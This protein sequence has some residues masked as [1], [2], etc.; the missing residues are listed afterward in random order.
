MPPAVKASPCAIT[1]RNKSDPPAPSAIRSP[2]SRD[3]CETAYDIT[4]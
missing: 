2:I 1:S 3:L 4:P